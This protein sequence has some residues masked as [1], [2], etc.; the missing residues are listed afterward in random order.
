MA[1]N[2]VKVKDNGLAKLLSTV[3][4]KVLAA[5]KG[6]PKRIEVGVLGPKASKKHKGSQVTVSDIAGFQEFGTKAIPKRPF[7]SGW[8]DQVGKVALPAVLQAAAKKLLAGKIDN[9]KFLKILGNFGVG[10][11]QKYIASGL[12]PALAPPTIA[13]KG[14]STPLIDTGILRSSITF[15]AV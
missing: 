2:A 15:R 5:T 1:K 12:K 10:G 9:D 7:I 8:F 14:S 11:I 13:R 4:R 6:A 3:K